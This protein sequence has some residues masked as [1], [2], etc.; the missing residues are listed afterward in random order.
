MPFNIAVLMLQRWMWFDAPMLVTQTWGTCLNGLH[1][2][3]TYHHKKQTKHK[4]TVHFFS[5]Q[6]FTAKH[7]YLNYIRRVRGKLLFSCKTKLFQIST[8]RN[9]EKT[10]LLT[11]W[12]IILICFIAR[13]RSSVYDKKMNG[14]IMGT[15]NNNKYLGQGHCFT[16]RI[17][18]VPVQLCVLS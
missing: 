8:V 12:K 5:L 2:S 18:M 7:A 14:V 16:I 15:K 4:V 10:G 6:T 3:T 11:K 9:R 1:K 17:S 13:K